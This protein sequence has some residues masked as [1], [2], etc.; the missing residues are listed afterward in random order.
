MNT[1][2]PPFCTREVQS[3]REKN[4][5][6]DVQHAGSIPDEPSSSAPMQNEAAP[7]AAVLA[8]QPDD[9]VLPAQEPTS[10]PVGSDG[11]T[12]DTQCQ[13]GTPPPCGEEAE[14]SARLEAAAAL[15]VE[16]AGP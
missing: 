6:P 9:A 8:H 15:L 14:R 12:T 3:N 10:L 16:M 11:E 13:E 7:H 1:F 2:T 5:T 4:C